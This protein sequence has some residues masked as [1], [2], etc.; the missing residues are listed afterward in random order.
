MLSTV[1]CLIVATMSGAAP[2]VVIGARSVRPGEVLLVTVTAAAADA[3]VTVRAFEREW[4][5]YADGRGRWRALVGIDLDA[6]LGRAR[7]EVAT[8]SARVERPVTVSARAFRTRRLTVDPDLVN[9]PPEARERIERET[10]ELTAIW[11]ASPA[12][13]L[14]R[15]AFVRP[16]PDG[17]NSAFG[18]RSIYNGEPRSPHAGADF[19]SPPGRPIKAP[20]AGR[21]VL[22]GSRYFSGNTVVIDHGAGLFSLLA[23][24]SEFEVNAGMTVAAGDVVGKVGATGRV[25]GPH[26]HW[27][28]RLNGTRVDPLALLYVTQSAPDAEHEGQQGR[29]GG[30]LADPEDE[31]PAQHLDA[32]GGKLAANRRERRVDVLP[33]DREFLRQ[34]ALEPI[35]RRGH[36]LFAPVFPFR[37]EQLDHAEGGVVAEPRS[38]RQ[39]YTVSA[40]RSHERTPFLGARPL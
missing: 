26:L 11:D 33:Q 35:R 22:A 28:V 32:R 17:A 9:P 14:W 20:A 30:N 19:L 12:E 23:H 31:G 39:R 21:V 36:H 7:L 15:G 8:R 18:T 1:L 16:V 29:D 27:T 34:P 37:V 10:Q 40:R 2:Q 25:T 13:R 4:P 5:V 6:P 3:P 24:L 38:K